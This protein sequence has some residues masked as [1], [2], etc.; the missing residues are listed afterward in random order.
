MILYTKS[1]QIKN[2]INIHNFFDFHSR[3]VF[4]KQFLHCLPDF[5]KRSQKHALQSFECNCVFH[6]KLFDTL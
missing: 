1:N 3:K 4:A 2:I 5:P 6:K